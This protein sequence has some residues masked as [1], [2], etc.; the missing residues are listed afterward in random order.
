MSEDMWDQS[1]AL[2]TIAIQNG[3]MPVQGKVEGLARG[4]QMY[5]ARFV[6]DRGYFVTFRQ[7]DPLFVFD[8]A[9]PS[10]PV[11]KAELTIPGFSE[12]MHPLEGGDFLLT[13]GQDGTGEGTT[14]TMALQIFD[15]RDASNPILSHK[16]PLDAWASEASTNHKAFTFWRD[17]LAVPIESWSSP[18]GDYSAQLA[19]FS[20]D[21]ETGITQKGLIDHSAFYSLDSSYNWCYPGG[22]RRGVFIEDFIY[23]VSAAGVL[24]HALEDLEEPVA[25]ADLGFDAQRACDEYYGY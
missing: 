11:L 19:L 17:M 22:V 9:D 1:N 10:A 12:Y 20:V 8:L 23:S 5:S 2:Y 15:V 24:V 25:T 4:E 18:T 3:K 7:V 21:P 16:L 13:I 6:G 14:G